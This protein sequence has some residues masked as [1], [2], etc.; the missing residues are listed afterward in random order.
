MSRDSD[1]V[2][3]PNTNKAIPLWLL[4]RSGIALYS[5][6]ENEQIFYHEHRN[7]KVFV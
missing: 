7:K 1:A 2:S 3:E 6:F 5:L 4:C